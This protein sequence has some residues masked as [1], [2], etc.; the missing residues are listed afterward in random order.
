MDAEPKPGEV[1]VGAETL[2][3]V[4]W[5]REL[6]DTGPTLL[7]IHATG[8]HA[9]I[10]D[11]I[12]RRLPARHTICIDMHGHGRSTGTSI[13]HWRTFCEEL[14][15][16]IEALDLSC[17][18]AIGHSLGGHAAIA[19]AAALQ[20]RFRSLILIDPVVMPPELYDQVEAIIPEGY[21]HPSSKRRRDFQSI[22]AMIER[23]EDRSPYALFTR[24]MLED[25]CR[26]ALMPR[27][28]GDGLTL[29]C[30]PEMEASVYT[31]RLSNK[32]IFDSVKAVG[33]PVLILR[34][35]APDDPA[36]LSF[37]S[38]PTWPGLAGAFTN[39]RE[40]FRPDLTHFM[41]MEAPDE[42][43]AIIDEEVSGT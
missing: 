17:V 33:I 11:Q 7:F 8:F 25:Y 26:Y 14:V 6:R 41:P 23:F 9:R 28:N 34:A 19:A 27:Q 20:Q 42:I 12:V 15:G 1:R 35:D 24:E 22:D 3:Y 32:G 16:F 30:A 4:E 39:A 10:W 36:G 40:I 21:V 31:A 37:T 18:V 13:T 38:S 43:A 2:G 29:A 5:H